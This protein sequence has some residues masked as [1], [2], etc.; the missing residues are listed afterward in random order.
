MLTAENK[1]KEEYSVF[2]LYTSR[3]CVEFLLDTDISRD[4]GVY[5]TIHGC[6]QHTSTLWV[7]P[8]HLLVGFRCVHAV[9]ITTLGWPN[10]RLVTSP[11]L[12]QTLNILYCRVFDEELLVNHTEREKLPKEAYE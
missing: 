7:E 1:N 2:I 5:F 12:T 4:T 11:S 6:F 10:L 3:L 9:P 8:L